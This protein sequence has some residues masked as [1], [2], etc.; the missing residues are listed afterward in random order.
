MEVA[1]ELVA[2]LVSILPRP[3]TNST[4]RSNPYSSLSFSL[5]IS[6]YPMATSLLFIRDDCI[7]CSEPPP[8]SCGPEEECVLLSRSCRECSR[9]ECQAR[10]GLSQSKGGVGPGALAGA[11]IGV[12]IFLGIAIG[13][14]LWY[15]KR[16]RLRASLEENTTSK[17]DIPASADLVL[18][19]PDPIEK[20]LSQVSQT[21]VRYQDQESTYHHNTSAH[22][23]QRSMSRDSATSN[24]FTDS[25]ADAQSIQTTRTE[26]TNAIP[27]ALAHPGFAH[28]DEA[29]HHG[30]T[31]PLRPPRTPEMDYNLDHINVSNDSLRVPTQGGNS[32]RSGT[33]GISNANRQSYMTNASYSSDF[34][35]APMIVTAQSRQML[36]M[37]KA[38][39][40]NAPN[41]QHSSMNSQTLPVPAA[42]TTL[43]SPLAMTSSGPSD[44]SSD[45]ENVGQDATYRHG[46]PNPFS[47]EH[48]PLPSS[49][50]GPPSA[51]TTTTFGDQPKTGSWR[52]NA[53]AAP[54]MKQDDN[55]RPSSISTQA[56]SVIDIG[57]ATRVN[58]GLRTLGVP[59]PSVAASAPRSPFR[60]TM[61]KLV[62]PTSA[63]FS[64]SGHEPPQMPGDHAGQSSRADHRV[65]VSSAVSTSTRADSILESF[66]FVPPSPISNRPVRSP[67]V[68][69]LPNQTF[70]PAGDS[71]AFSPTPA[72]DADSTSELPLVP[73]NR[74]M[75]GMSTASQSSTASN[76]LGSFPFQIDDG[77][78]APPS[79]FNGNFSQ[80][81]GSSNVNGRQRASLDTLALTS[82][83][84]S[85]PLGFDNSN[86]QPPL[87]R[88]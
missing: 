2:L 17:P 8:C 4:T 7:A 6:L 63:G 56:G 50:W 34:L 81:H 41:S 43:V 14:F 32:V 12:L 21:P 31:S 70:A 23:P 85:Y 25:H 15:R 76:G 74:R 83:L 61:G 1:W 29:K 3:T 28:H 51:G 20:H 36:N 9:K 52:P 62:T 55:S 80:S 57:S 58:V 5:S 77:S 48:S 38:E 19:R 24:P 86:N 44:A 46:D 45:I 88:S 71:R 10:P 30:E 11:V 37:A 42:R 39:V 67:P 87:P 13:L 68:S 59:G 72:Q 64:G 75:L 49:H 47:D 53:P 69:P 73:P 60:T 84:S 78:G 82:D 22:A 40:V 66:P 79:S 27:I 26:G 35:E 16:S 33:S 65:S 54:W 18:S